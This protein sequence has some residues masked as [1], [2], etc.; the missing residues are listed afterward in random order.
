MSTNVPN[1]A[2]AVALGNGVPYKRGNPVWIAT[3]PPIL[4]DRKITGISFENGPVGSTVGVFFDATMVDTTP[5]GPQNQQEYSQ[6]K[7]LYKGT[8]MRIVWSAGTGTAPSA[9]IDYTT[10]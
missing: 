9:T 2:L 3:L 7:T 6:P 4:R 1:V 5:Y 10:E 8:T